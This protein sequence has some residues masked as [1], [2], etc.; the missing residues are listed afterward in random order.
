MEVK[1]EP[2]LSESTKEWPSMQQVTVFRPNAK[3]IA[4]DVLKATNIEL[5][6]DRKRNRS[7]KDREEFEQRRKDSKKI[8]LDTKRI[9]GGNA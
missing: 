7:I 9:E 3:E 4:E 5:C 8:K 6:I 2:E 1:T